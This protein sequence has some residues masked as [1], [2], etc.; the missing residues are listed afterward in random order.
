MT[1]GSGRTASLAAP[2]GLGALSATEILAGYKRKAFTPRDVV[3]E[4]IAALEATDA[5]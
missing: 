2:I 4:T 3:D 5:A 1:D